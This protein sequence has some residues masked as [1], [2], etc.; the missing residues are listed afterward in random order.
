[1]IVSPREIS[2]L[3]LT[4][5]FRRRDHRRRRRRTNHV[6]RREFLMGALA[7]ALWPAAAPRRTPRPT[8]ALA[9][10]DTEAHV[11]AVRLATG[12]VS[13]RVKTLEGPR[14]IERGPG[15]SAIVAHTSEGAVTLLEGS[16][17]RVRRVLR[18]FSQ[19]RYTAVDGT[20]AYVT[21]SG[22]GEVAVLDLERGRVVRRVAAGEH[23][24]HVSLA[25]DGRTL[26]VALGSSARAIAVLDVTGTPRPARHV[27]PPFLAH[28][29][30]FAPDGRRV[31]VTAGRER[32]VAIYLPHGERPDRVLAADEAPQHVGF[33]GSLAF[34]TSGDSGTLQARAVRSG[35]LHASTP[36]PRGSYNVQPGAGRILSPSLMHGTLTFADARG[37][38]IASPKVAKA[39]HDA[40]VI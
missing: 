28:D 11:V 40:C 30:G 10:A 20:R 5:Q 23:A 15:A 19:P 13:A 7:A 24:R 26:W 2:L 37:R 27:R 31:W 18:G 22:T 32:R 38:L 3:P 16:P 39:A 6:D 21:D 29:V 9:T 1:M 4:G 14:S 35:A 36:I 33:A 17:P 34:V 25:P 12:K 8:L